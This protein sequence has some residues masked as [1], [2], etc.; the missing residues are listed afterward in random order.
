LAKSD[1]LQI[2]KKQQGIK[3][4][5][6]YYI[7]FDGYI[8]D[9]TVVAYD[10]QNDSSFRGLRKWEIK[11]YVKFSEHEQRIEEFDELA[12]ESC[13]GGEIGVKALMSLKGDVDNM[14]NFLKGKNINSFAIYNFLSRLID[15]FFSVKVSK[16]M[17]GKN[18]Y[19]VFAGGDDLFII[20]AWDEVIELAKEIE[21]EFKLFCESEKSKLSISMGLIMTK[22]N[23]PINFVADTSEKAL[24]EAKEVPGKDAI[25]LFGETVKWVDYQDMLKN[26]EVIQAMANNYPDAF[27]MAFW[28]RLL[29]LCDMRENLNSKNV[30]IK[31]ALWRSKVSYMFKRNIIDRHKN[32]NFDA[33]IKS[34]EKNIETYGAAFKVVVS[35]EIYKR[36]EA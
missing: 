8:D 6:D 20:G 7:K 12:L 24:E 33:V 1:A 19:T 13:G 21:H 30:N 28:Y 17:E 29:E 26:F 32:E 4:F 3:I 22:S 23:K 27:N 14:G 2:T 25:T 36:R 9:D 16:K 11:S 31:N 18:V 34:V 10:I 5:G 35:E 15:Y